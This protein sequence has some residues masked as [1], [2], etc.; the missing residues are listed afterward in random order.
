MG[1]RRMAAVSSVILLSLFILSTH[2]AEASYSGQGIYD[3]AG[4]VILHSFK[5]RRVSGHEEIDIVSLETFDRVARVEVYLTL[6]GEIEDTFGYIYSMSIG[7]VTVIYDNGTFQVF[8]DRDQKVLDDIEVKATDGQ[9]FAEIPKSEMEPEFKINATAQEFILDYGSEL[10]FENYYDSVEGEGTSTISKFQ[11]SLADD[12]ND[13]RFSFVETDVGEAPHLDIIG[14]EVTGEGDVTEISMDLSD[15]STDHDMEFTISIG[16]DRY[17]ITRDEAIPLQDDGRSVLDH[18]VEQKR[19]TL[20]LNGEGPYPGETISGTAKESLA[21]GGWMDDRCPDLP[22]SQLDLLPY[23]SG[24]S[25]SLSLIIND[26]G[27]GSLR[28]STSDLDHFAE[29]GLIESAD[30]DSSGSVDADEIETLFAEII[31]G[32]KNEPMITSGGESIV[33][34]IVPIHS[35]IRDTGPL[36]IGIEVNFNVGLPNDGTVDLDVIPFRS[37]F[38]P[39]DDIE[40]DLSC[41]IVLP[42]GYKILPYT[43][44]PGGLGNH[45]T[46]D[47]GTISLNS[48]DQGD[49]DL[50]TTGFSFEIMKETVREDGEGSVTYEDVPTWAYVLGFI[51]LI[52]I[53]VLIIRS[54]RIK[55]PPTEDY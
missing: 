46:S 43:I 1:N 7:G 18:T 38:P 16:T 31:T 49:I 44:E 50:F 40:I 42:D 29:D 41:S 51:I 22:F 23:G 21:D 24:G 17:R 37:T 34:S 45:F 15:L 8:R 36:E 28:I 32:L 4:D 25:L 39:S 27:S 53:A 20:R 52:G 55:E 35:G 13:V 6:D 3:P 11:L 14:M 33:G 47:P 5:E 48:N 54:G 10:T 2:M 9:I 12:D 19:V 30:L 26:D